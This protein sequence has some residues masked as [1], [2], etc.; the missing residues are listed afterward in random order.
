MSCWRIPSLSSHRIRLSFSCKFHSAVA[1]YYNKFL[2]QLQLK[3]WGNFLQETLL[4][5]ESGVYKPN[6]IYQVS[7]VASS[8]SWKVFEVFRTTQISGGFTH[9]GLRTVPRQV[10][11]RMKNKSHSSR[12]SVTY[13]VFLL[14]HYYINASCSSLSI[15][16]ACYCLYQLGLGL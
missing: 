16:E 11:W 13:L 10:T 15:F 9:S 2:L 8:K 6:L 5:L 3:S 14:S 12:F 7:L 4:L 1:D